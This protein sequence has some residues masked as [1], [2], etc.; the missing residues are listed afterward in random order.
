MTEKKLQNFEKEPNNELKNNLLNGWSVESRRKSHKAAIASLILSI[1]SLFFFGFF[2][3]VAGT[4][5]ALLQS[6]KKTNGDMQE[7]YSGL[8]C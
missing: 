5:L 6:V 7:L 3:G 8:Q 1:I 4:A 2:L